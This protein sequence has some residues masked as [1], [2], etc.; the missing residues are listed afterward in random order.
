MTS[1]VPQG[2]VLGPLLSST[3]VNRLPAHLHGINTV[4]FA[5]DTTVFIAGTSI[6]D[7]SATPSTAIMAA[8]DWFCQVAFS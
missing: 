4:L 7:I 8:Y 1:R 5:D 3:S 2:S 6:V